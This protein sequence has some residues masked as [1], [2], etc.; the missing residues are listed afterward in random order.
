MHLMKS[1]SNM[2]DPI[3]LFLRV[4]HIHAFTGYGT[5]AFSQEAGWDHTW[6][7]L[8]DQAR[9]IYQAHPEIVDLIVV[10]ASYNANIDLFDTYAHP[11]PSTVLEPGEASPA[12][13]AHALRHFD[14]HYAYAD[15]HETW[16]KGSKLARWLRETQVPPHV[17]H[18]TPTPRPLE[19][20]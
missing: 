15:D 4:K 3:P 5:H 12:Q 10:G 1:R 7:K 13:V 18:A 14:R 17:G 2:P 16:L 8:R 6:P 19:E 11:G 20:S 9:E